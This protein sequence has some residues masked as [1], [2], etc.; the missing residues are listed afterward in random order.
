[1]ASP[2]PSWLGSAIKSPDLTLTLT[3]PLAAPSASCSSSPSI[4]LGLD[5]IPVLTLT[6][7]PPICLAFTKDSLTGSWLWQDMTGDRLP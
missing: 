3:I 5:G 1:M 6:R 2:F 7:E 4:S